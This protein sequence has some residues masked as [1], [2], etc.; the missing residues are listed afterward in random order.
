[1]EKRTALDE[2]FV[3]AKQKAEESI[4][5][6][7]LQ[8]RIDEEQKRKAEIERLEKQALERRIARIPSD[9]GKYEWIASNQY[10]K[11]YKVEAW[12]ALMEIHPEA[13]EVA[14]FDVVAFLDIFD[15]KLAYID[16]NTGLMWPKK[17]KIAEVTMNWDD[18]VAWANNLNY[19]GY[20][21]WR[22]PSIEEFKF[23]SRLYKGVSNWFNE[24][25][26]SDE[27]LNEFWSSCIDANNPD[28]ALCIRPYDCYNGNMI[29]SHKAYVWPVRGGL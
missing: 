25:G 5:P 7:L 12:N 18:A 16:P 11:D 27:P 8:R 15:I 20:C 13:R 28:L 17:V 9:I 3:M 21:D 23:F 24:N 1:M 22:L 26:F 6:G 10:T 2:I 14:I 4:N 19:G 29:K